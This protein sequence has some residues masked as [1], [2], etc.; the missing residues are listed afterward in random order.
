METFDYVIVGAGSAGCVLAYRL[1]EAGHSVCVLEAGPYDWNPYIHI[2]AGI[3]KTITNRSITWQLSLSGTDNIKGREIP[4]VQ[5]RVV[6][7]SGSINGMVYSRGQRCDYDNWAHLGAEGW[8]YEAVLPYFRKVERYLADADPRYRGQQGRMPIGPISRQDAISDAFIKGAIETGSKPNADYN[9]GEQEGVG[10]TQATIARGMRWSSARAYLHPA[11]RRFGI[12]VLTRAVVS[13][14]LFE[15]RRA[16]GVEFSREGSD[17][18]HVVR[19]RAETILC[20]GTAHTPKLLQ[21]SGVGPAALLNGHGIPVLFDLPGVGRNLSDHFAARIVMRARD[22]VRTI[23][24]LAR[25]LPLAGE[26]VK[27]MAGRPSIVSMCSMAVYMFGKVS[28]SSEYNDYAVTFTPASLKAGATRKLDAFP[29]VTSGAWQLRPQSRGYVAIRSSHHRDNPIIAP[30]YLDAE[31]DR[32]TLVAGIK[33]SH[34]ILRS[35]AMAH[36]VDSQI[37]PEQP[38]RTDDEWLDY[39]RQYGMTGYHLVGTCR[40]GGSDDPGTVVDSRL[41]VRGIEGL[42]VID[43]SVM[44]TTPSANTNAATTMIAEKGSE[45]VLADRA[46][47]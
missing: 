30:N 43:A 39:I 45:M 36:I 40:M 13:R 32:L 34:A 25:G 5:G 18:L 38:C 46:I 2:P 14:V 21:L 10:Y 37:L 7:G 15:G 47:A 16:V 9:G 28:P 42:R 44:P 29:G 20:A 8:D 27:W 12:K 3:M 4:T 1:A 26:I 17:T 23:N 19:A 41:R 33:R 35:A 24:S 11:R 6:G 31:N 22:N